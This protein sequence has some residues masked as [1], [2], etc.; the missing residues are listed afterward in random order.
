MAFCNWLNGRADFDWRYRPPTTAEIKEADGSGAPRSGAGSISC[1]AQEGNTWV[2][3][4]SE[5]LISPEAVRA[6]VEKDLGQAVA[7]TRSSPRTFARDLA[8][9]LDIELDTPC[10]LA[11]N[12]TPPV[13]RPYLFLYDFTRPLT[14]PLEEPCAFERELVRALGLQP[15]LTRAFARARARDLDLT[16]CLNLAHDLDHAIARALDRAQARAVARE[17]G[18]PLAN[19]Y[20]FLFWYNRLA[21]LLLASELVPLQVRRSPYWSDR[22]P[23]QSKKDIATTLFTLVVKF[24]ILQERM[25]GRLRASDGIRIVKERRRKAIA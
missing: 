2:C 12:F 1:W 14:L 11:L 3:I 20:S 8:L 5:A 24:S 15:Q 10:A 16:R 7:L 25:E 23:A 9:A 6:L 13:K 4:P 18:C 22:L 21:A 19:V 17:L